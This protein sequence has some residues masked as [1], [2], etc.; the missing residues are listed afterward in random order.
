M[1]DQSWA[2][3]SI[4][5]KL[6]VIVDTV[7]PWCYVGKRRLERALGQRPA[8]RIE[9]GWRPFQL[10]PTMPP[11]GMDRQTYL[12]EK[13]GGL[14]RARVRYRLIEEAGEEEGIE[15]RFDLISKTPNTIDSHRLIRLAGQQELQ[16]EAVDALFSAYFTA[17]RDIGAV[18]SLADIGAEIG[19][20]RDAT[21][22]YLR[23]SEDSELVVA[24]DELARGMGVGGVPCYIIDRK[25]A[26]S[27]AQSPE[28]FHQ[29]FDL[30]MQDR[31]EVAAE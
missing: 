21:L 7:C 5:M 12:A 10:N 11:E 30:A 2:E 25:Y 22:D 13:F 8:G 16:S 26:I 28:V 24:E 27:G 20:D 17:G 15:F 4:G 18:E 23:S 14:Q 6:D 29:I 3:V 1:I 19:L 9:I 31:E